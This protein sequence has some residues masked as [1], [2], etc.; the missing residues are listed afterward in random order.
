MA[1]KKNGTRGYSSYR[2][3]RHG[4]KMLA[5]LLALILAAACGFL[6]AQ[7]YIVYEADGSF[8]FD[9]PWSKPQV[10][11]QT[12][13]KDSA[14]GETDE[15]DDLEITVE[16]PAI[17]DTHAVELEA[18]VLGGEWQTALDGLDKDVNAVAVELKTIAAR[19]ITIPRCA[20]RSTAAR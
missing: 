20:A 18:S 3:R 19:S 2:G 17:K 15:K 14:D 8:R 6:F 5:V 13:G 4:R 1:R 10:E 11:K 16:K 12:Q 7:R 9:L